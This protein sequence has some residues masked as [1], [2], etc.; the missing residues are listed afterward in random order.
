MTNEVKQ[1]TLRQRAKETRSWLRE[2]DHLGAVVL[3]WHDENVR[4]L[5]PWPSDGAVE[6]LTPPKPLTAH[7]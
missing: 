1:V 6:G 3:E 5:E 7:A 4:V 2:M